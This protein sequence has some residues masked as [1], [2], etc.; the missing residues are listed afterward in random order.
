[1]VIPLSLFSLSIVSAAI[2]GDL[3]ASLPGYGKP[4]T[5]WYSGYLSIPGGKHMHYIFIESPNAQQ[6]PVTAWF[7]GGPG[8]SSLEGLFAEMGQLWVDENDPCRF[9]AK[10]KR[11]HKLSPQTRA[12]NS[13]P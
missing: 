2:T 1:M 5:P 3:V 7:N 4:P 10:N 8:C 11:A 12:P 6:D 9:P 13:Q